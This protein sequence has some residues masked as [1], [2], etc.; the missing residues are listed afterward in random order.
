[1]RLLVGLREHFSQELPVGCKVL[2]KVLE[3]PEPRRPPV[4]RQEWCEGPATYAARIIDQ[5]I[6][7]IVQVRSSSYKASVATELE[8]ETDADGLALFDIAPSAQEAEQ[9]IGFQLERITY[10]HISVSHCVT[11]A[12]VE[13]FLLKAYDI[14]HLVDNPPKQGTSRQKSIKKKRQEDEEMEVAKH[15]IN[16]AG[17]APFW[18][19][20]TL[21]NGEPETPL[22]C[23]AGRVVKVVVAD[24]PRDYL[25]P[26]FYQSGSGTAVLTTCDR[27]EIKFV[28]PPKPRVRS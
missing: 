14:T 20:R 15:T 4:V 24:P 28:A 25:L 10:T 26:E 6:D 12:G 27:H 23:R 7:Y 16:V 9:F 5:L 17:L 2:C 19:A 13:G 18:S 1:I 11:G 3:A 22:A 8:A 21:A